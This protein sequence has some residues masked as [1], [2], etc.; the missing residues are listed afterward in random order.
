MLECRMGF[1]P[2]L[3]S[4][5]LVQQHPIPA[6][7][8]NAINANPVEI[9]MKTNIRVPT[10]A[11]MLRDACAV[12]AYLKT[13]LIT[14]AMTL[15]TRMITKV[16]KETRD[17]GKAHHLEKI[18]TGERKTIIKETMVPARK[19]ANMMLEQILRIPRI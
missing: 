19:K 9:H 8:M 12:A 17:M 10:D 4:R 16:R 18:A 6:W 1:L 7:R 5:R 15:P 2:L 14:E 3:R 13:K 11:L